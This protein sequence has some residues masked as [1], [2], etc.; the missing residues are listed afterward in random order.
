[1]NMGDQPA[2]LVLSD[3]EGNYYVLPR[4]VI[5]RGRV[6]DENKAKVQE[7]VGDT[8]GYDISLGGYSPAGWIVVQRP[9]EIQD[10]TEIPWKAPQGPWPMAPG[11]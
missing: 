4:E 3:Q 7:L 10:W 9:E 8:S 2:A 11:E 1:M 5:E 6:K